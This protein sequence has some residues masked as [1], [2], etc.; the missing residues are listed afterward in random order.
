MNTAVKPRERRGTE[1]IK[2]CLLGMMR[3][4]PLRKAFVLE[5]HPDLSDNTYAL[6]EELLR[7][8]Y[9]KKYKLYWMKTFPGK[10][11]WNLPEGVSYFE[12]QPSGFCETIRRA[13]V[14]NTS[15]YIMDCNSF[16]KKRRKGQVRF[17]LGHGMPI[18]IDLEYSRKFGE[19]DRYMVQS[20]F[21]YDIFETQIQV[22]EEVLC[23]LGYPRNDVLVH[24]KEIPKWNKEKEKYGKTILWMPTYRQHRAHEDK[25]LENTYPYGC[26]A[27][28]QKSSYS[29]WK[30]SWQNI[31][32][33]YYFVRI[34]CR[35]SAYFI[36][37]NFPISGLLSMFFWHRWSARC[38]NFGTDGCAHHG[39]S[40]VY[41][42][43]LLTDRPIALT[44]ADKE[45]YFTRFT[46]AFPDYKEAVKGFYIETFSQLS[47]FLAEIAEGVDS[48]REERM[49]AK[50]KYHTKDAGNSAKAI[51]D[52]LEKEYRL[53]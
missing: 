48:A 36:K 29:G 28:K 40:S 42:D 51:V 2:K 24:S 19:C 34:R 41:F 13:Y 16:V 25:A 15:R 6:Y 47:S 4:L 23:P 7:R 49:L 8:G 33:Y 1:M 50:E 31:I 5:S 35:I 45:E 14:L 12:N 53:K 21:W 27:S 32:Y 3:L 9:H 18:K 26:R 43:Y 22:P 52:L 39:Y 46:L 11:D 38:M 44:I 20:P 37:K 17:H 10:P 30:N